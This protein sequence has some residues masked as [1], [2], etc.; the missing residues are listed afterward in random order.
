VEEHDGAVLVTD[1]PAL[2]VQLRRVVLAPEDV[3]QLLVRDPLGVVGHL[4]DL[5]VA[6]RVRADV[7]VGGVLERAALVADLSLGDAVDLTERGLDAPEA[8]G[9]ECCLLLHYSS[10][11]LS[12]AELMQ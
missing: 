11:N 4:D 5:G 12:A 1:V 7:L 3:E 2:P 6:G 8:A 9:A 10:S